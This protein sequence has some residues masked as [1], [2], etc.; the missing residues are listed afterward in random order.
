MSW[1]L[2]GVEVDKKL[3]TLTI[4]HSSRLALSPGY[5]FFL[6][7]FADLADR[8]HSHPATLWADSQCGI[9]WAE[10]KDI[11]VGIIVYD[12]QYTDSSFPYLA[13]QLTAVKQE[14]RQRGI[15]SIM[16]KYFEQVALSLGCSFTRA[17]VNVRNKTRL[18]TAEKDGLTPRLVVLNKDI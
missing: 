15:H 2:L 16:N 18:I 4:H 1:E 3:D 14:Y 11:V 13:I 17:T 12:K 5:T 9:I 8:G 7:E 10:L 6:R